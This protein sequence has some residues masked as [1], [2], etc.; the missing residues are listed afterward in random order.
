MTPSPKPFP[1]PLPLHTIHLHLSLSSHVTTVVQHKWCSIIIL[2]ST[3]VQPKHH[4]WSNV[5]TQP[6]HYHQPRAESRRRFVCILPFSLT[7][8]HI[9]LYLHPLPKYCLLLVSLYYVR[10]LYWESK[11]YNHLLHIIHTT[12]I[13]TSHTR[14]SRIVSTWPIQLHTYYPPRSKEM[15]SRHLIPATKH[16]YQPRALTLTLLNQYK[17]RT[18]LFL[19]QRHRT[20]LYHRGHIQQWETTSTRSVI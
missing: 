15:I 9:P 13:H 19:S 20:P 14:F 3:Q 5:L 10:L 12:S 4:S 11:R 8:A 1:L 17:R 16:R 6:L 7:W 2:T 18:P